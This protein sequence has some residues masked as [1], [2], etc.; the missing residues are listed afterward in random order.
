MQAVILAG[1]LGKRMAPMTD[2]CPKT[3]LPIAGRPFAHWQ[4]EW[5]ASEGVTEI[6]YCVGHLGWQIKDAIGDNFAG[7]TIKYSEEPEPLG[8]LDA[9]RNAY[10]LLR[11]WFLVVYGDSY[12]DVDINKLVYWFLIGSQNYPLM[13]TWNGIDYGISVYHRKM[14]EVEEYEINHEWNEIGSP[15][16]FAKLEQLLLER[17]EID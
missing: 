13:T 12:L 1:G 11:S 14:L 17:K 15:E 7:M 5:L 16:G 3:L 4:L 10:P 6:V 8:K 2:N 9:I